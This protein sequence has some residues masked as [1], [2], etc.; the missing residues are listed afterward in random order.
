MDSFLLTSMETHHSTKWALNRELLIDMWKIDP[1]FC[2]GMHIAAKF[3][4]EKKNEIILITNR[5]N[6]DIIFQV[7]CYP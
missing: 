1:N 6:L 5:M 7:K 3:R 2:G 4:E